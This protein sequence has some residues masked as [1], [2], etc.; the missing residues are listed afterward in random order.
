MA[1]P[2]TLSASA[3][4]Q[5]GAWWLALGMLLVNDHVLKSAG[6][7]PGW[8]TGKLSDV[9]GLVVAP[10]LLAAIVGARTT[11]SRAACFG[12]VAVGFVA[13]NV[14]PS[15]SD[16]VIAMMGRV[17]ITWRLWPDPTDLFA[18]AI[19]PVA[20]RMA[21]ATP[22]A[23]WRLGTRLPVLAHAMAITVGA[24]ACVA[25][26]IIDYQFVGPFVVNRSHAPVFVDVRRFKQAY[27]CGDETLGLDRAL[28]VDDFEP[29]HD[30]TSDGFEP[31]AMVTGDGE[32]SNTGDADDG[33]STTGSSMDDWDSW[34]DPPVYGEL[35]AGSFGSMGPR[36][37]GHCGAAWVQVDGREGVIVTWK[38]TAEEVRHGSGWS[39]P[40]SDDAEFYGRALSIEGPADALQLA[41]GPM[42]SILELQAPTE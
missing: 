38:A 9:A 13:I 42:L 3:V 21:A 40:E 18:L 14:S 20:W 30:D 33:G 27:P 35:S 16:S 37:A 32:S 17:G 8:L 39:A 22:G 1:C 15:V 31:D 41:T 6:I 4:L 28:R 23:T 10:W 29:P 24:F 2:H 34:I 25:T 7:L 36:L 12:L 19:V 5:R 11:W 26:S